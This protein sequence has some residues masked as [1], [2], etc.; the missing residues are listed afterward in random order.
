MK[1]LLKNQG[2][3]AEQVNEEINVDL[4]E[5][6][7]VGRQNTIRLMVFSSSAQT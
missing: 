2:E 1:I 4:D 3:L 7:I 6:N 5:Q